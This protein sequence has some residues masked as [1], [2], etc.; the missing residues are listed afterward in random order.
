M[1][2]HVVTQEDLDNDTDLVDLGITVGETIQ[3]P[4]SAVKEMED[5]EAKKREA[6]AKKEE[7]EVTAE[8]PPVGKDGKPLP[9]W[10][11]A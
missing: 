3:Y 10:M 9:S 11:V 4:E 1:V 6:D 8:K 5:A 7:E 2:D